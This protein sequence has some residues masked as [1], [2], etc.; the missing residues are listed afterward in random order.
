MPA[1]PMTHT[2]SDFGISYADGTSDFGYSSLAEV[3]AV[4]S[5]DAR[6]A[7]RYPEDDPI[8]VAILT[9]TLTTTC[10]IEAYHA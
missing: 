1:T 9:R 5:R 8:P 2:L 10:T 4:F 3:Q 6:L 7:M